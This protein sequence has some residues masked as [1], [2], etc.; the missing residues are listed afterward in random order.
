L[1]NPAA[2]QFLTCF[3]GRIIVDEIVPP[4]FLTSVLG[5]LKDHSLGVHIVK[6]TGNT[7]N[8]GGDGLKLE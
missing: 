8:R 4:S 7:S 2:V 6:E 3:L 5:S 1:D